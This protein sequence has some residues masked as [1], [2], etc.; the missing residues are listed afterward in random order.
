MSSVVTVPSEPAPGLTMAGEEISATPDG[1]S[2]SNAKEI[3]DTRRPQSP[4]A[5]ES[6]SEDPDAEC[7]KL[8]L[9]QFVWGVCS[10]FR[11]PAFGQF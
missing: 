5:A 4:V 6:C 10:L 9:R 7:P 11:S 2:G 3:D 8:P 1:S